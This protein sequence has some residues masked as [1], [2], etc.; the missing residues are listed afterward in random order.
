MNVK[1]KKLIAYYGVILMMLCTVFIVLFKNN[2]FADQL[3]K[4][5]Y[6]T[7]YEKVWEGEDEVKDK[8]RPDEIKLT[9]KLEKKDSKTQDADDEEEEEDDDKDIISTRSSAGSK[10]KRSKTKK[11]KNE[12]SIINVTIPKKSDDGVWRYID[13]EF[14]EDYEITDVTEEAIPGYK[15]T[16]FNAERVLNSQNMDI[17]VTVTNTW[18]T[19]NLIINKE[20]QGAGEADKDKEFKFTV[21]VSDESS[22]GI[23][24]E[25]TYG[26]LTFENGVAEF[27]LK[28]GGT[29]RAEG[30]PINLRYE[31][32]EE[33][34]DGYT[35]RFDNNKG[36]ITEGEITVNFTN[37]KND[38]PDKPSTSEETGGLKV[39]KNVTGSGDKSKAF[40]FR[41]ELSDKTVN[42]IFGDMS[43]ENG[44]AEFS[45]R[46]GES[47]TASGL[48]S[49]ISYTVTESGNSGYS[50]AK[51]GDKGIIPEGE[52]AIA[53]F[54]NHKSSGGGGGGNNGGGSGGG[55]N[56]INTE[57]P[58]PQ[59]ET[60]GDKPETP[61]NEP[62]VPWYK[63]PVM[64]D[65]QFGPG[66][67]ND[68][69]N[70]VT[71]PEDSDEQESIIPQLAELY[72]ENNDLAG[73]LTVPGTE[74]GYPVMLS[75]GNP[76]Y[77]QHHTFDKKPDD[78]GIPFMGPYCNKDSMNVLIH[79][80]NMR[81]VSQFGYIWNYQYPE[82]LKKNPCIDF[83]TLTDADGSYE[84][85][86][87]FFAPEYAEGTEN[88][89]W[90][91]RY[92]GDMNKEQFDYFV[93][94]VKAMSLYDTGVTAEYGDRLITLETCAS[95]K[96]STR[97]VVVARKSNEQK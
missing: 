70:K 90:W 82:F 4:G 43:F 78:I 79:G 27:T 93:Q 59:P 47:M 53:E 86:A 80:H 54:T 44:T 51:S 73:W 34:S 8:Y 58:A 62:P 38:G 84:V 77:Y 83:K 52:T 96:D 11:V 26:D 72:A 15:F 71:L 88:V 18:T 35:V 50:V 30:L 60:P 9:V 24:L 2:A 31:V 95:L 29:V 67:V 81:D 19:G 39:T 42:G 36:S 68:N 32:T 5:T 12:T 10:S 49:G 89:F 28:D 16:G 64:G 76:Y 56:F 22:S 25:G 63:L 57:T 20:V 13:R 46:H 7:Y 69:E 61:G 21:T 23:I 91:Y 33:N 65:E 85:M 6:T 14:P 87:V 55:K 94:N 48:P 37:I 41:V 45:L 97:L 3:L 74:F 75:P 92:M 17:K 40:T 1:S 66:F